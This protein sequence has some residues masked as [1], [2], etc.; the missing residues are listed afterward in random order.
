M[1]VRDKYGEEDARWKRLKRGGSS[2]VYVLKYVQEKAVHVKA[3]MF[4]ATPGRSTV[5][6]NI[7]TKYQV[8]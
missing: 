1:K 4:A 3:R 7:D 8:V 5:Y 2:E 6:F